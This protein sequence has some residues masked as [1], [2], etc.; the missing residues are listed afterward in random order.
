[1]AV[2]GT[3]CGSDDQAGT[4]GP[5][6]SAATAAGSTSSSGTRSGFGDPSLAGLCEDSTVEISVDERAAPT[7]P[8][9]IE[10]F[11]QEHAILQETVIQGTDILY[12]GEVVGQLGLRQSPAGG[13]Y[14]ESA[15]WCYP[16]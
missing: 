11:L 4:G 16:E 9:A 12:E 5:A 15:E 1:L 3:S 8:A 7:R 10:R 14:V 6:E 13:F 2:V